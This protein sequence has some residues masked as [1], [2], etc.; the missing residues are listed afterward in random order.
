M[1]LLVVVLAV[2]F[3]ACAQTYYG[4]VA[5]DRSGK[6]IYASNT[7][8]IHISTDG[9]NSWTKT[10]D[11]GSVKSLDV[12]NDGKTVLAVF[13]PALVC[14]PVMV[15]NDFGKTWSK[16]SLPKRANTMTDGDVSGDGKTM[17]TANFATGNGDDEIFVSNDYG[18]T[19]NAVTRSDSINLYSTVIS[20]G[21]DKIFVGQSVGILFFSNNYGSTFGPLSTQPYTGYYSTLSCDAECTNML[22][23]STSGVS[24]SHDAGASWNA[25][26]SLPRNSNY[27]TA[28]SDNGQKQ[29]A[30]GYHQ[31]IYRSQ[32]N[33]ATWE[34]V[35][36]P[37]TNWSGVDCDATGNLVVAS[38]TERGIYV[39]SDAGA[40]WTASKL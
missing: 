31:K 33:G 17:V 16:P 19:F 6:I 40:T 9:G 35:S 37:I 25:T 23:S 39:S 1:L 36:T 28:L 2:A 12:S 3:Q 30:V 27:L 14:G 26:T 21:G 4:K 22:A 29:Y 13:D 24:V 34:I 15:S 10:T 32:D 38:S 7:L 5:M 8:G 20:Q 18:A 11:C